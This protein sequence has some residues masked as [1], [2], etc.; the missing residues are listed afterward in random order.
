MVQSYYIIEIPLFKVN[1]KDP[2]Q[3]PHSAAF[4]QVLH[5]LP[6]TSFGVSRLKWVKEA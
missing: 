6:I 1:S 2:D 3:R 5:C 4:D